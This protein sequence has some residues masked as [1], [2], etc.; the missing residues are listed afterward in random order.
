MAMNNNKVYTP[1]VSLGGPGGTALEMIVP[2][3]NTNYLGPK[4]R[5]FIYVGLSALNLHHIKQITYH[6]SDEPNI[7]GTL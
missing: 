2:N 4:L 5:P 1:L 7:L 6:S 3:L